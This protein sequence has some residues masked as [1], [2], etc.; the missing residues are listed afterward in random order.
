MTNAQDVKR[1]LF[2][3]ANRWDIKSHEERMHYLHYLK[4]VE[5]AIN[6]LEARVTLELK[7]K[8]DPGAYMPTKAHESDAG[9]DLYAR[10][11]FV[12]PADGS[13]VHDTG[14]HVAIPEGYCGLLVSK[15]GL[16]VKFD[17]TSTG[18]IDSGYTGSIVV[19]L[20]NDRKGDAYS[21]EDGKKI[22]Q[23]VIL[24]VPRCKL[25]LV[26]TLED[27]ERGDNGFGSTGI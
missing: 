27:T 26:D 7:V 22:T 10:E 24:P 17:L 2:D 4:G 13:A 9:Y 25:T 8:L 3:E 5:D 18:L 21:F 15:S 23:L 11:D 1:S 16:N 20:Y 19:K 14:V 6:R 12:V